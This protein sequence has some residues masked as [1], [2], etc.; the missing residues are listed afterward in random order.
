[1]LTS[2]RI[3]IKT[4]LTVGLFIL[5]AVIL[6]FGALGI[7]YVNRL[8]SDAGMILKDNHIS[9][10]Y[11]NHMLKALDE[12]PATASQYAVFEKNLVLEENNITEPGE[13]EATAEVRSLF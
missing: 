11:C 6:A 3:R 4:K 1:M 8:K 5:F 7:F 12:L 10:E 9:L 13:A 2:M